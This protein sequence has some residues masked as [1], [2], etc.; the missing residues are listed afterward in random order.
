MEFFSI[1]GLFKLKQSPR[2]CSFQNQSIVSGIV[3]QLIFVARGG[4]HHARFVTDGTFLLHTRSIEYPSLL[5][6][7]AV[8]ML[9]G[10]LYFNDDIGIPTLFHLE[11]NNARR[12]S[13]GLFESFY[14][15]NRGEEEGIECRDDSQI[16]RFPGFR[17][18]VLQGGNFSEVFEGVNRFPVDTIVAHHHLDRF[19]DQ[20]L[21]FIVALAPVV[22]GNADF[23]LR[24]IPHVGSLEHSPEVLFVLARGVDHP[25]SLLGGVAI[26]E[27]V[28]AEF[29]VS[30]TRRI[31]DSILTQFC[32][33][34]R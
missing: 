11:R 30:S 12:G 25:Q 13:L 10:S 20:T 14:L 24:E 5:V 33:H 6:E 32:L 23:D 15:G 3:G 7:R 22:V 21:Y 16:F 31:V 18:V 34:T 28:G 29:V 1:L 26:G 4:G 27:F 9:V 19:V 8:G 2:E 17:Q